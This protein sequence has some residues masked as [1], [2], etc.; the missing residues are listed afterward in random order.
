MTVTLTWSA[1]TPDSGAMT[2]LE[3]STYTLR[4]SSGQMSTDLAFNAPVS[5]LTITTFGVVPGQLVGT[6]IGPLDPS[7]TWYFALKTT[8]TWGNTSVLSVAATAQSYIVSIPGSGGDSGDVTWADYDRDGDLD[9]VSGNTNPSAAEVLLRNDSGNFTALSIAGSGGVTN[10]VAWGDV[11]NDGDPDILVSNASAQDHNLLRNN[12]GVFSF[13][14]ISFSSGHGR[15]AAWGDYD[16]D[17]DLDAFMANGDGTNVGDYLLHNEGGRLKAVKLNPLSG[18]PSLAGAFGDVDNDGD[19]DV[20]VA[21]GGD[22]YLLRNEG[23][24]TFTKV[25]VAGTGGSSERVVWGDYDADGDLD[26]VATNGTGGNMVLMRNDGGTLLNMGAIVGSSGASDAA[27]GDIDNDGDL[28]VVTARNNAGPDFILRNDAGTFKRL[29]MMGSQGQPG[30][31]VDLGD[32]D[33]DGDLDV[34]TAE[35]LT[36]PDDE[37]ILRNDLNVANAAPSPPTLASLAAVFSY[38]KSGSTLVFTWDGGSYDGAA[39]T[40]TMRFGLAVSTYSLTLNADNRYIASLVNSFV[41]PPMDRVP[42]FG[43]PGRPAF[44]DWGEGTARHGV[45]L[46]TRGAALGSP[47]QWDS[48]YYFRVQTIDVGLARSSWSDQKQYFLLNPCATRRSVND[49]PWSAASTWDWGQVPTDCSAVIISSGTQVT[50]DIASATASTTSVYGSLLFSLVAHSTLTM[51]EGD[52]TVWPGGV[53]EMGGPISGGAVPNS[54]KATLNLALGQ[55]SAQY[56]LLLQPGANFRVQGGADKSPF[57]YVTES[58]ANAQTFFKV[59]ASSSAN[60]AVGDTVVIG[61]PGATGAFSAQERK[62]TAVSGTDPRTF[63][64]DGALSARVL[65]STSAV[66]VANLTRNVLIRSKGTNVNADSAYVWSSIRHSTG[67][68]I[69][70]GEFAYLGSGTAGVWE[71]SGVYIGSATG[72]SFSSATFRNGWYGLA[73]DAV[74]STVATSVAAL[75][76][77]RGVAFGNAASLCRA[78]ESIAIGNQNTGFETSASTGHTLVGLVSANNSGH[79]IDLDAATTLSSA[80]VVGNSGDGVNVAVDFPDAGAAVVQGSLA[81]GNGI[82][83]VHSTGGRT[84][85]KSN[86]LYSNAGDGVDASGTTAEVVGNTSA[87]NAAAGFNLSGGPHLA[88]GNR[89]YSNLQSGFQSAASSHVF[90]ENY[91]YSNDR[92]GFDVRSGSPTW[93]GGALGRDSSLSPLPNTAGS[94]GSDAAVTPRAATLLETWVQ[95]FMPLSN[96]VFDGDAFVSFG[97]DHA[98]GTVRVQGDR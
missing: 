2:I 94:A 98:T 4:W 35:D 31:T 95:G 18:I 60:W 39:A 73:F 84:V 16:N 24:G 88:G 32:Y 96:L 82:D 75:N 34:I 33:D 28:D 37:F 3:G 47:L 5:E 6:S 9:A 45:F 61:R 30:T 63:T 46:S 56:G 91:S 89:A 36:A 97:H 44:K 43:L 90:V 19:L 17:G 8:D 58:I 92:L 55:T 52:L 51:V 10:A 59:A 69:Q 93:S 78:A 87:G 67:L 14:N 15:Q 76:L 41:V 80:V 13:E 81:G 65:A 57:G 70:Q 20:L 86:S 38:A 27:W 23:G 54:V 77:S 49:G 25:T 1:P 29:K 72:A 71:K 12:G 85:L 64:V 62:I 83:G 42:G 79:G 22:E 74:G 21:T 68:V 48:T 50:V 66:P 53:L 11:D 26:A 40:Q 7:V